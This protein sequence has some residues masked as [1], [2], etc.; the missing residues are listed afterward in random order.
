MKTKQKVKLIYASPIYDNNGII[1]FNVNLTQKALLE[2]SRH[3]YNISMTVTS[4]RYALDS[5]GIEFEPIEDKE[6]NKVLSEL[7]ENIKYLLSK[8]NRRDFDNLAELLPQAFI[9]KMQVSFNLRSLVHFLSLRIHPSS[10]RDIR[11]IAKRI[12]DELP[13][14]YKELV[15][16]DENIAKNYEK[17]KYL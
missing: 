5:M 11:I 3:R 9:Y 14:K 16:L 2:A 6:Y 15:L 4:S 1:I 7:N 8:G 12:I 17:Y 13:D 10:H